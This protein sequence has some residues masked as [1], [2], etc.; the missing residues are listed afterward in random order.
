MG[1]HLRQP[2]PWS[3]RRGFIVN[4]LQQRALITIMATTDVRLAPGMHLVI[5]GM[6][7]TV[8]STSHYKREQTFNTW[9]TV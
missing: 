7:E 3:F 8:S 5:E 4:P 2:R 6:V 9:H 1:F